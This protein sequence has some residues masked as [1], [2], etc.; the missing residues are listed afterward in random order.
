M[1]VQV[2]LACIFKGEGPRLRLAAP[3]CF[4]C[5]RACRGG[6]ADAWCMVSHHWC[7]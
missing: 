7:A 1:Q 2:F 6:H 5:V 4:Y 3:Y